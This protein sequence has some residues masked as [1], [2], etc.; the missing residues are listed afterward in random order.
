MEPKHT[1]MAGALGASGNAKYLA[2]HRRGGS[3]SKAAYPHLPRQQLAYPGQNHP[4]T[5][6]S[7]GSH[8]QEQLRGLV[9]RGSLPNVG[10]FVMN[11]E[12][13]TLPLPAQPFGQPLETES[14][15]QLQ[16]AEGYDPAQ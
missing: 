11:P 14:F 7:T 6:V 5:N 13:V 10:Q 12:Q 8:Q 3:L 16:P 4:V 9:H 1:S 15:M 2:A